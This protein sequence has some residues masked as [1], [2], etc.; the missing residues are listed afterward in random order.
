M[1]DKMSSFVNHHRP[2]HR[3]QGEHE[4]VTI[5]IA[6]PPPR[7]SREPEPES[8]MAAPM[9]PMPMVNMMASKPRIVE[10]SEC[11]KE[12][13]DVCGDKVKNLKKRLEEG[14]VMGVL[15]GAVMV[16]ECAS[17]HVQQLK[18]HCKPFRHHEG[19]S[20]EPQDVAALREGWSDMPHPP[21]M[22]LMV[23]RQSGDCYEAVMNV[24]GAQV[25][26]IQT[27]TTVS[28][29]QL[30][31][32]ESC[33]LDSLPKIEAMCAHGEVPPSPPHWRGME[34]GGCLRRAMH[35]HARVVHGLFGLFFSLVLALLLTRCVRRAYRCHQGLACDAGNQGGECCG[36]KKNAAAKS[37]ASSS[38]REGGAYVPLVEKGEVGPNAV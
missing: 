10:E 16:V 27:A 5:A 6:R 28:S 24:C 38:D 36:A 29:A 8:P 35:K 11:K 20:V 34:G 25:S 30:D 1:F 26:S 18:S 13:E 19:E 14:D 37:V 33:L 15:M 22:M 12:W 7:P 4:E 2:G 3:H 17:E 21:D 32:L 31:A 9:M 23:Q